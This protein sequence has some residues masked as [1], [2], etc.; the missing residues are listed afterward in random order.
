MTKN[1]EEKIID[2]EGKD[3]AFYVN[4]ECTCS[5]FCAVLYCADAP[6]CIYKQ[7]LRKEQECEELKEQYNCYAC[8]TCKGKEDYINLKRHCENAIK[9]LHNKQAELE[10]FKTSNQTTID[11]LKAENEELKEDYATAKSMYD[12]CQSDF[13]ELAKIKD[14]YKQTLAEIKEIAKSEM[15]SKEFM[16]IQCMLNGS[17]DNKNKVLMQ[18]LQKINEVE[19]DL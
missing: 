15:D 13:M 11:Q 6:L 8:D 14:K 5:D 18:I 16:T 7:W 17:V 19:D 3:C 10:L 4:G 12:L 2:E 9:S 1:N